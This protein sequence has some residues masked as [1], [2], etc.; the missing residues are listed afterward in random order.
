[1]IEITG[2]TLE[3]CAQWLGKEV[4]CTIDGVETVKVCSG[5]V[6]GFAVSRLGDAVMHLS[7]SN[8]GTATSF[9]PSEQ[10]AQAAAQ[11]RALDLAREQAQ[12]WAAR[13]ADLEG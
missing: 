1:M 12:R 4:W 11:R 6:D 10:T 8:I 13:V 3:Q 7:S 2:L 5:I 9:W